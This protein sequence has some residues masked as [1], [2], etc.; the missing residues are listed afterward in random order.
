MVD[1]SDLPAVQR[2]NNEL[3]AIEQATENFDHGGRIVNMSIGGPEGA[4]QVVVP[5]LYMEYPPQMVEAIKSLFY[6]R[7]DE[8][9]QELE[10]LGVTGTESVNPL[11]PGYVE[12]RRK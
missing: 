4:I 9:R 10:A 6:A 12:R 8:L 1:R 2:I 7:K 11:S 3:I 5:T